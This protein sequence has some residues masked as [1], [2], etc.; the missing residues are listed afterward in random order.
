MR[1][2][3]FG[4][5]GSGK[6]TQAAI[7]EETYALEHLSTGTMFREALRE[8]TAIGYNAKSY[9]DNG[10]LVP[11]EIV[12]GMA[13]DA[14]VAEAYDNFVLDGF[15]RTL[16]QAIWLD[17]L[18]AEFGGSITMISLEVP[19]D[20]IIERLS[21]R[22]V[23]RVTGATYHLRFKPPPADVDPEEL[24]QRSDDRPEAIAQ[25]LVVYQELT[26]PVKLHYRERGALLEVDGVGDPLTVAKRIGA[27]ID[28][29]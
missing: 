21:Q 7:L 26:A 2:A 22:R 20:L 17:N 1:L 15:P 6:G 16:T 24:I 14:I 9:I 13:R 11:D 28:K 25:R 18:L 27:E 8:G 23:H 12:W 4:P 3:L 5:P 19:G 10:E 29:Q